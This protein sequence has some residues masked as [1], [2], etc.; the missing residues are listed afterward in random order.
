MLLKD[1]R[2]S[3]LTKDNNYVVTPSNWSRNKLIASGLDSNKINVVPHGVNSD[4]FRPLNKKTELRNK[5]NLPNNT[6][7]FL[8][9]GGPFHNKGLDVLLNAFSKVLLISKNCKLVLKYNEDLYKI[10]LNNYINSVVKDE[11]A[12]NN[13]MEHIIIINKTLSLDELNS[14]YNSVDCY[15]SSYR[16]EG[17]N[18]PV[19]EATAAGLNVLVTAGG[20]TDDFVLMEQTTKI[21][22][23]RKLLDANDETSYYMEPDMDDLVFQMLYIKTNKKQLDYDLLKKHIDKYSWANVVEQLTK[24]L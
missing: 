23:N 1:I 13:L 11:I 20:S 9:I 12:R 8:N 5:F 3:D 18:I 17:F 24:I 16:A 2:P 4:L 15:V 10:S 7:L 21:K 19:L 6:F 14:L 22:S